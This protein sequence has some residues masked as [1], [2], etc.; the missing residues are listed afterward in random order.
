M[1]STLTR[2]T[3]VL[4]LSYLGLFMVSNAPTHPSLPPI[5]SSCRNTL[6]HFDGIFSQPPARRRSDISGFDPASHRHP[7]SWLLTDRGWRRRPNQTTTQPKR[8][9]AAPSLAHFAMNSVSGEPRVGRGG[10]TKLTPKEQEQEVGS[11]NPHA[12]HIPALI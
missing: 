6:T 7:D 3:F 5:I 10:Q 12:S 2:L 9:K 1:L 4:L 11:S 8:K